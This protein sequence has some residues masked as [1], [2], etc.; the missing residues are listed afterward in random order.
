MDNHKVY[1][2]SFEKIYQLYIQKIERKNKLKSDLDAL[3]YWL[4]GY[5][6]I[7]LK[8]VFLKQYTMRQFFDHA[9]Q[10]N[11]HRF[12]IQGVI[13]GVRVEEITHPLM[14]NIRY[15]DKLVDE[16]A[17]GKKMSSIMREPK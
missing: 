10:M 1:E 2:M 7:T 6:D 17:R 14:K 11:D 8:N 9:P 12:L 16:L 4:T 13:C 5:D 3:I 15:L